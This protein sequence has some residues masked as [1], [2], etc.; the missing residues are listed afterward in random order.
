MLTHVKD[1]AQGKTTIGVKRSTK[2]FAVRKKHLQQFP[3][4]AVCNSNKKL[5]VHHI[6]PFNTNPDLELN[7]TN[8]ITL[9]EN[10]KYGVCCHLFVGHCGNYKDIN[11]D[12]IQDAKYWNVK[13][14]KW[15]QGDS[16]P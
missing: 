12:V 4:C 6:K 14:T 5:E 8:L 16:N 7:P 10:R 11:P 13:L 3:F 9:C 1:V 2:W 15:R